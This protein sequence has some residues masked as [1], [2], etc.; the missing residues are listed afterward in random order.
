MPRSKS[1][2]RKPSTKAKSNKAKAADGLSL[3][4]PDVIVGVTVAA[5]LAFL[6]VGKGAAL[7]TDLVSS[8]FGLGA[9][10]HHVPNW[11]WGLI[12]TGH[13]FNKC[14]GAKG[15]F[16][17]GSIVS[18]VLACFSGYILLDAL[19]CNRSRLLDHE[20][21]LTLVLLAWYVCNHN[22]PFTSVNV[23]SLI[24]GSPVGSL[25]QF[26]LSGCSGLFT[27]NLVVGA[28]SA[29]S[30]AG[31][32]GHSVFVPIFVGTVAGAASEF[33]PLNKGFDIKSCSAQM[34]RSLNVAGLTVVLPVIVSY[35]PVVNTVLGPVTAFLGGNLVIALV[36]ADHLFGA[37]NPVRN[38][39]SLDSSEIRSKVEGL[40]NL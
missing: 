2:A 21:L 11:P 37:H 31:P 30:K 32:L 15:G 20:G 5:M 7:N 35:L 28:C 4:S 40:L 25:L 23:W 14:Q 18:A 39:V 9:K 38:Y 29:M 33:V 27:A 13:V 6:V 26:W 24:T 36:V 34:N 1:P 19:E 10:D 16:W 17:I 3:D 22:L 12:L 8:F